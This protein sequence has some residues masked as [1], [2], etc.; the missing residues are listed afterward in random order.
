MIRA[1][2]GEEL[3]NSKPPKPKSMEF[4]PSS[5]SESEDY[6]ESLTDAAK[7]LGQGAVLYLQTM[8]TLAI[9]FFILSVINIPIYQLYS[10]GI[11]HDDESAQRILTQWSFGNFGRQ[12]RTCGW[13]E[14]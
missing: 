10:Q 13:S 14:I 5:D 9:M 7:T 4:E 1:K 12:E 3:G 11:E 2:F 6:G 8:K